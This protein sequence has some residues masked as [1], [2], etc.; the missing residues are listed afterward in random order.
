[1]HGPFIGRFNRGRIYFPLEFDRASDR[2]MLEAVSAVFARDRQRF[3]AAG[4]VNLRDELD[5]HEAGE[6]A[7]ILSE[8]Q[9][10]RARLAIPEL[11]WTSTH[12][13]LTLDMQ[14]LE[15]ITLS[16]KENGRSHRPS[17][18]PA[19]SENTPSLRDAP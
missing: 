5:P 7:A 15:T 13:D 11:S 1:M 16:T 19:S 4:L 17:A 8:L 12:D 2:K 6:L 10:A 9:E 14:R 18:P 3:T